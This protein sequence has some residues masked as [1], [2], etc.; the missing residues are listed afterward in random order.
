MKLFSTKKW[1]WAGLWGLLYGYLAWSSLHIF[2]MAS[3]FL[4]LFIA[5]KLAFEDRSRKTVM[6]LLAAFLIGSI[7]AG[8][9]LISIYT[10][11]ERFGFY[12][13]QFLQYE[14]AT[15]WANLI[16]RHWPLPS[17][18]PI[19]KTPL[20]EQI[21]AHAKGETNIGLSLFV[22]LGALGLCIARLRRAVPVRESRRRSVVTFSLLVG[23]VTGLAWLNMHCIRLV[24]ERHA[25]GLP[26]M[27]VGLTY[28]YYFIAGAGV[29]VLRHR[30]WASLR[31]LDFMFF[32][33]ALLFGFLAFG[34][35]YMISDGKA[36]ASPV[37]FLIYNVAGFSGI[38]AT[39]RWGLILSFTLAIAVAVF[40]SGEDTRWKGKI[41]GLLFVVLCLVELSPGINLSKMEKVTPYQWKPKQVDIFLKDLPD[42]AVLEMSDY[43]LKTLHGCLT[44]DCHGARL[45][46][47]TFHKK[48]LVNGYAHFGP[49]FQDQYLYLPESTEITSDSIKGMRKLGPRYWVVHMKGWPEEKVHSF[50]SSVGNLRLI[51][52]FN[53]GNTLVY[54]DPDP[55][56]SVPT[57]EEVLR[58]A[59][60]KG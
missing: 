51:A 15:N 34:P 26:S 47:R 28:F 42:G 20:W 29:Y 52:T 5:W 12:R 16:F 8:G 32:L 40:F 19:T 59:G 60:K 41:A 56:I 44:E 24:D 48:L 37:A 55:R 39:A 35:Y 4:F 54:E 1:F 53:E 11:H 57:T 33:A 21:G 13:N 43:P 36:V 58:S 7:L 25:A 3:A 49:R 50:K 38:G 18:N 22:L 14:F 27:A 2:V 30:I 31:H 17:Y 23:F 9:V 45:Y 10:A 46:A 6:L